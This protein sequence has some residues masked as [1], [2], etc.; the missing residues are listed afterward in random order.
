M[1]TNTHVE[2][3]ADRLVHERGGDRGVD[4]ARQPADHPLVADL[5]ADL[6]DRVLD[7]RDVRP[8]RP[9]AG[10]VVQERLAGL[11][12]RARC[13]RPR[14]GTARRRSPR[15]RSS[16]AATGTASVSRGDREPGRR[17]RD[18]VAVA[19]PHDLLGR[20]V[21][22]SS[23][24]EPSTR[25]SVRPYSP[26]P[27][28]AHLA[29][30]IACDELRAV[31]DAEQR[32]PR[33]VDRGVDRRRAVDVH[34]RGTAREDDRLRVAARASRRSASSAARSRCTRAPRARAARSAARTAH[35]SRR[36]ERG[37]RRWRRPSGV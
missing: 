16:S 3:V 35:R 30:E 36:R 31:T 18:G 22:R 32:H 6:G 15:S 7:D 23:G 24:D 11:P 20:L 33:V 2:L 28:L 34:R 17:V 26:L 29:A 25:S 37:R 9:A 21:R 27:V 5:G 1:S 4:A 10:R 19:H 12:A 8:R 13:A 14:G